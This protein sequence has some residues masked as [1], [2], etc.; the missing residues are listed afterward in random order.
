[1]FI[2]VLLLM[3]VY[4]N[5]ERIAME[6]DPL[7]IISPID[8]KIVAIERITSELQKQDFLYVKIR[9]LPFD[10]GMVR[11]PIGSTLNSA[12]TIHGLFLPPYKKIA[13][14]LN[15]RIDFKCSHNNTPFFMRVQAGMFSKKIYLGY[16]RGE[17]KA[18]SR[19]AFMV[20]GSVE[21]LLPLDSRV[22]VSIGAHVKGG[23]SVIGYFA[24]KG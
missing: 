1:M 16:G 12:K 13:S 4:R 9:S 19:I 5:P 23:E 11:F 2:V 10:V 7:A 21:L 8:G 24:Y 15:E 17:L 6:D 18:G 3:F 14:A 20:D 22:K